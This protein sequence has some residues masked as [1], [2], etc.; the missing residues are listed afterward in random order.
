MRREEVSEAVTAVGW[1]L[2]L[3][4]VRTRVRTRIAE[5]SAD[6][7]A[8]AVA[9]AG[10]GVGALAVDVRAGTVLLTLTAPDAPLVGSREVGATRRISAAL[11]AAGLEPH[12]GDAFQGVQA[13]EIAV[14]ALDIAAVRPFWRALL[15]YVDEP[16]GVGLVDPRG[17]SPALWFQQ[18]DAPP[19][20]AQPHPHRRRRCARPGGQPHRGGP[21]GRRNA[22][23]RRGGA[24]LLGAGRRRGQRSLRDRLAGPGRPGQL[25]AA[26]PATSAAQ[27]HDRVTPAPPCP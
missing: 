16:Q 10:G 9:A 12:P 22:G 6:V 27:P 26:S 20:A 3:G 7:A 17:Q 11:A 2:V 19:A 25:S 13:L 4:G 15:D 14:D 1:R 5:E 18:M 8:R 21:R 24:G 23:L